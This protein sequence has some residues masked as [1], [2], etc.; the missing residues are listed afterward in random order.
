M[1]KKLDGNY[2]RMLWAISPGGSAPQ[3]NNGRLPPSL[4]LSKLDEPDMRDTAG[5]VRTS[6]YVMYSCVA[7]HMDEQRQD[8]QHEPTC[9]SSVSIRDVA[10]KTLTEAMDDREGGERGS[11]ISVLMAWHDDNDDDVCKYSYLGNYFYT[12][13]LHKMEIITIK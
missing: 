6:S 10:L 2:G 13:K 11:G 12:G 9:S 3:S 7:F 5:E 1:K 4:K 8:D